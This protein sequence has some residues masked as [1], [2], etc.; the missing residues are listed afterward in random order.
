MQGKTGESDSEAVSDNSGKS[1]HAILDLPLIDAAVAEDKAASM[2]FPLAT[3]RQ[4]P[5]CNSGPGG[6]LPNDRVF[7]PVRQ[8]TNQVHAGLSAD[9]LHDAPEL[10]VD[11][12]HQRI[13]PIHI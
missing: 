2:W 5:G 1:L 6:A 3:N 13:I 4:G 12:S 7:N 8:Q 11:L 10:F 9:Y